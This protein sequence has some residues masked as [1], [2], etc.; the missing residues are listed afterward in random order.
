MQLHGRIVQSTSTIVYYGLVFKVYT[1]TSHSQFKVVNQSVLG[2]IDI[3]HKH[4]I[5]MGTSGVWFLPKKN[6]Y[7]EDI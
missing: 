5:K 4:T 3:L 7:T 6:K 2:N 1:T